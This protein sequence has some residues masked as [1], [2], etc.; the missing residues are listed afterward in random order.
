MQETEVVQTGTGE[1]H[2]ELVPVIT[3]RNPSADERI[4]IALAAEPD[5]EV[6]ELFLAVTEASSAARH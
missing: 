1:I 3:G 2:A 5:L 4:R 6:G